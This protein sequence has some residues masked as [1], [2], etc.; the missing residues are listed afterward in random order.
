[1]RT[2]LLIVFVVCGFGLW[3]GIKMGQR[4]A[5]T[6]PGVHN[7]VTAA[8]PAPSD[9]HEWREPPAHI[10]NVVSTLAEPVF[11]AETI[12][13]G[14]HRVDEMSWVG[15]VTTEEGNVYAIGQMCIYG[16][17]TNLEPSLVTVMAPDGERFIIL[18]PARPKSH[19]PV[20]RQSEPA[21]EI[22]W[23]NKS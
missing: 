8:P 12:L 3:G 7:P 16:R 23:E 22:P 2:L 5:S 21:A 11:V 9:R 13:Y 15:P 10:A 17:V 19:T 20:D 4:W 14:P 1:M 18:R 6:G